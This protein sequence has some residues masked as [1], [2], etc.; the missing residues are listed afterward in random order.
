LAAFLVEAILLLKGCELNM[1]KNKLFVKNGFVLL[2][3]SVS[4]VSSVESVLQVKELSSVATI[5]SNMSSYGYAPSRDLFINLANMNM[6]DLSTMWAELEPVLKDITGSD[7]NISSYVLYKNFPKEV[8]EMSEAEYWIRQ[9]FV[10]FGFPYSF[11]AQEEKSRVSVENEIPLK[12]LDV[13]HF[14]EQE[15]FLKEITKEL[16]KSKK[17]WTDKQVESAVYIA[18]KSDNKSIF[19]CLED[20]GFKE[21]GLSLMVLLFGKEKESKDLDKGNELNEF[22]NRIAPSQLEMLMKVAQ[23][24]RKKSENN[25]VPEESELSRFKIKDAT[26]VLRLASGLSGSSIRISK[27]IKFKTFNRSERRALLLMLENSNNLKND[28]SSRK[29]SFKRL[30]LSLRPGDYKNKYPKCIEAYDKLYNNKLKSE[31]SI[32]ESKLIEKDTSVFSFFQSRPGT[33]VKS[34]HRLYDVFGEFAIF[35]L[36]KVLDQLTTLQLIQFKKYLE[37]I[38]KREH[39]LFAPNGSWKKVQQAVNEKSEIKEKEKLE[40]KVNEEI[41]FRLELFFPEGFNIDESMK[42]LK[43][44]TNDQKLATYGRGTSFEIPE[45]VS[46]LRTS[47]YWDIDIG[48]FLDNTWNFFD[49]N[50]KSMGVCCWNNILFSI[51][52]NKSGEGSDLSLKENEREVVKRAAIFSG[53]SVNHDDGKAAQLIDLYLSELEAKDVRYAVWSTLSF[54][55]IPFNDFKSAHA[56]M[57]MGENPESGKLFEASRVNFSF[58]L[59]ENEKTK[60]IAYLDVKE[61]KIIYCDVNKSLVIKSGDQNIEHLEKFMP[62]YAEYLETIPSYLDVFGLHKNENGIPMLFTDK[63]VDFSEEV[64][65]AFVFKRENTENVYT[66]VIQDF[67]EFLSYKKER[68]D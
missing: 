18:K 46:F 34:F 68:V 20:F 11:V 60:V 55:N 10:Y 41:R 3:E 61:R 31:S 4:P 42:D 37:T 65:K 24:N 40:D 67:N 43:F 63:D 54:S 7:H 50:W 32:V 23:K 16:I 17:R 14:S 28:V 51:S 15:K 2:P 38:N 52:K 47:S 19:Y 57:Q 59:L 36:I 25:N 56:G 27:K 64:P 8:L 53:D 26:D 13:I 35:E 44:Q 58:P 22:K 30:F 62:A 39:L 45:N 21:N 33:F 5:L 1:D 48:S 12:V 6:N 49:E 29:E 9:S 66:E